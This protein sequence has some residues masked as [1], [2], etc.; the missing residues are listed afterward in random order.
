MLSDRCQSVCSVCLYVTLVYYGQ[1][2]GWIKMKLGTQVGLGPG[3]IVLDGDSA[4]PPP[5]GHS[6][7][8]ISPYLLWPNGWMD[9]DATWYGGRPRPR[10]FCVRWGPSSPSQKGADLPIF[11]PCLLWPNGW[12]DQDVTCLEV[13]LGPGL[14]VLDGDPPPP[15]KGHS[16]PISGQ[17]P[18]S[19][20]CWMD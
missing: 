9:S 16:P 12:M 13:G 19:P 6:P 14:I 3:Q 10:R 7:T 2:V 4:P 5:K 20:K 17:C 18:L 11:C 1:M 8:I 15:K